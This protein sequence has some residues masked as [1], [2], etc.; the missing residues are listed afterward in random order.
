MTLQVSAPG[1]QAASQPAAP[2]AEQPMQTSVAPGD[3]PVNTEQPVPDEA[4]DADVIEKEW[5]VKAKEVIAAT[6]ADPY[7]QVLELNKLRA[8]YMKKRYNKDIKLPEA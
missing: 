2:V 7:K 1:T 3:A 5:V 4:A 6:K 8:D